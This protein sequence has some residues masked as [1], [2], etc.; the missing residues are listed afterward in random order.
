MVKLLIFIAVL[1]AILA[2]A[3]IAFNPPLY[4]AN[5]NN[6]KRND[7]IIKIL[8]AIHQYAA[9]NKG[10]F[11]PEMP[12]PGTEPVKIAK[13]GADICHDLVPKY[14]TTMPTDPTGING[15]INSECSGN[16]DTGY[17]VSVGAYDRITITAPMTQEPLSAIITATR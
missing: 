1:S 13:M 4:F 12:A 5:I 6:T 14:L 11:P 15:G 16:Y 9:D 7:D 17:T 8:N 3:I 2:I 10:V